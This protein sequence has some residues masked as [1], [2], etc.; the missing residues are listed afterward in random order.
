[1]NADGQQAE[2]IITEWGNRAHSYI[3]LPI[4][5][6]VFSAGESPSPGRLRRKEL[7]E[8]LD[9]LLSET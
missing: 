2:S 4:K 5:V 3:L 1:M 9:A 7:A 6:A 8:D